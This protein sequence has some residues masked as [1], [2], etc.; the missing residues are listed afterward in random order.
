M[1]R[2][3]HALIA[4]LS[5]EVSDEVVLNTLISTTNSP[6]RYM[7]QVIAGSVRPL[8]INSIYGSIVRQEIAKMPDKSIPSFL[9][10]FNLSRLEKDL[11]FY[12]GV[13]VFHQEIIQEEETYQLTYAARRYM[14]NF[15]E[16]CEIW[17]RDDQIEIKQLG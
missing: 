14:P 2:S 9:S 3:S 6:E 15:E 12:T 13:G 7:I 8:D 5:S 11:A 1:E 10:R 4:G 16:S 17:H